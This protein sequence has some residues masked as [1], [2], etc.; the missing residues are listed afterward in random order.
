MNI[1]QVAEE[2]WLQGEE[3]QT[4]RGMGPSNPELSGAVFVYAGIHP[5]MYLALRIPR[6]SPP[7]PRLLPFVVPRTRNWMDFVPR[8]GCHVKRGGLAGGPKLSHQPSKSPRAFSSWSLA[9]WSEF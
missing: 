3:G 8:L 5:F 2:G 1:G 9:K 6:L 7:H 4:P